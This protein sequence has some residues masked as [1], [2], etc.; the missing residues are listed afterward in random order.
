M[1]TRVIQAS[2]GLAIA[3]AVVILLLRVVDVSAVV[4]AVSAVDPTL[5]VAA[6]AV[7]ILAM[8]VRSV[9]WRR[10]LHPRP[11]TATLFRAS[12]IGFA[13]NYL[14][15]LRV[16][17]LIRVY[18]V[19]QWCGIAYGAT[20]AS[21]VVERALDGL[22]VSGILLVAL[23]FIP[24][25][26]YVLALAMAVGGIFGTIAVFL[27]LA[28]WR[29]SV[30]RALVSRLISLLPGPTRPKLQRVACSFAIVL[31]QLRDWRALP[32][33]L[34][35]S[36]LGWICQF[37]V[38]FVLMLGFPMVA[39]VPMAL[40]GGGVANFATLLPSA[41]G[42]VGAFDA[43]LI[44]LLVDVQRVSVAS[45]AAYTLVVHA[46][47]VIPI[48]GLGGLIVW[49][50]DFS[51]RHLVSLGLRIRRGAPAGTVAGATVAAPAISTSGLPLHVTPLS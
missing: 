5:I 37:A 17:E 48:V 21:L 45:A 28:S 22:A 7:H 3:C 27:M 20:I 8:W 25:P 23:L 32:G 44:K 49:R 4:T 9:L 51:L 12:I 38:F 30:V 15:P 11:P 50:A 36:I 42:S 19:T 33:L 35:L 18:L 2:L 31:D 46:V 40:L 13:V 41:P 24:V 34:A 47:I 29:I 14:M 6:V 1:K 43:S 10:L 16:G 39:S 26:L